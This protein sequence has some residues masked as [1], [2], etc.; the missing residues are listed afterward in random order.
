MS[1]SSSDTIPWQEI[2][3]AQEKAYGVQ[4][5]D[6]SVRI[7]CLLMVALVVLTLVIQTWEPCPSDVVAFQ[8]TEDLTGRVFPMPGGGNLFL[9]D[10]VD[11]KNQ[12]V[13]ETG[14]DVYSRGMWGSAARFKRGPKP[15][16]GSAAPFPDPPGVYVLNPL[17]AA[18]VTPEGLP[19]KVLKRIDFSWVGDDY[20]PYFI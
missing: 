4:T 6:L 13:I 8:F 12:R 14:L 17:V 5:Y 20:L 7:F 2:F 10:F 19:Y 16:G 18:E 11:S 1:L 15:S 3:A 9:L